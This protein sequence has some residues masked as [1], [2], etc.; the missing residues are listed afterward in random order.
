VLDDLTAL[1]IEG[2]TAVTGTASP[3]GL[4]RIRN[5]RARFAT[6]RLPR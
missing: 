3:A 4:A 2:G 6:D 5:Y 1:L